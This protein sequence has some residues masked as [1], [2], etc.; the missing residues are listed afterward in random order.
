[1]S[2]P[3]EHEWIRR[4]QE[5]DREAFAALVDAYWGRIYRWLHGLTRDGHAAED[6][7]QDVL[8][9]VWVKLRSFQAGTHF[10]AWL[11]RIAGNCYLDSR[12]ARRSARPQPLPEALPGRDP[13]PVATLLGQETQTRVEAALAELPAAYRGPFLLR[14][15]E[16]LSFQEIAVALGLTEETAR[17][18]VF[19]ARRM[20]LHRLGRALDEKH[21]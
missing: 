11:F 8:V 7:T 20:L 19:K 10:R 5:G 21:E 9:K 6:L 12:R 1:M 3:D 4:A 18:R 13:D 17:W 15:Q 14:T 2:Q 16:Q